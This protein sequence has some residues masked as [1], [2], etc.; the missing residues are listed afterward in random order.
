VNAPVK[1]AEQATSPAA[2]AKDSVGCVG[3]RT[4]PVER[5]AIVDDDPM[6]R[7]VV[8]DVLLWAGY[9]P[10][11]YEEGQTALDG[12]KASPP[13]AVILD[14]WMPGL[15]GMA[16]C[17][18]LRSDPATAQLPIMMLTGSTDEEDQVLGFEVGADDYIT[19]PWSVA[20][21][22]A[23]LKAVLRR[24]AKVDD[25]KRLVRGP[26]AIDPEHRQVHLEGKP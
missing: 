3:R 8:G 13:D 5:I 14:L 23:R 10:E 2:E 11:A 18:A 9:A 12:L 1:T 20:V 15:D 4:A 22:V 24:A 19:K 17:R 6:S 7:K 21:L 26:M 16:V 25:P